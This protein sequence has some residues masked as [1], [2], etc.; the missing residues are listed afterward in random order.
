S[1][2][3][4]CLLDNAYKVYFTFDSGKTWKN[5]RIPVDGLNLNKK[6]TRAPS[7]VMRFMDKDRGIIITE[8]EAGDE[9][10]LIEL[11]TKDGGRTWENSQIPI[12]I[13]EGSTLY[14]SKDA[15]L[16]TIYSMADGITILSRNNAS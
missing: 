10:H 12:T 15:N 16:L 14:L 2:T 9:T 5:G 7:A 4:G 6:I 8:A 13:T 1:T 3:E 11:S